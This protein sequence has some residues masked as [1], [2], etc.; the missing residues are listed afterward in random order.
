MSPFQNVYLIIYFL[1]GILTV[2]VPTVVFNLALD[3]T[4][5]LHKLPKS[6]SHSF[7]NFVLSP[8][9]RI[10]GLFLAGALFSTP[11]S[12]TLIQFIL[13]CIALIY[14][15]YF[16]S[17]HL[18]IKKR[19]LLLTFA[20]ILLVSYGIMVVFPTLKDVLVAIGVLVVLYGLF[21][22]ANI[23]ESPSGTIH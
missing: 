17:I 18:D 7:A 19:S 15:I 2:G 21:L 10:V 5:Q 13:C 16:A 4:R 9:S 20:A 12:D 6:R 8:S 22:I 3:H 11:L 1:T 23:T 14:G